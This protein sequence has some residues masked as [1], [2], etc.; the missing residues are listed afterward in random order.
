MQID[1]KL[2]KRLESLSQIK[3]EET[4]ESEI[5]EELNKFLDF[6]E[7]LNELDVKNLEATF[8]T[9][10]SGSPFR[11]DI[12]KSQSEVGEKILKNAPKSADNIFIVPKIIE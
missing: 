8:S 4:K 6:V 2:L 12:P 10:D 7:I 5:L 3:I 11:K 9:L 1:D